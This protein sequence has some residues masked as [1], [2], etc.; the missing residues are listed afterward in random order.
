MSR[1]QDRA[2]FIAALCGALMLVASTAAAARSVGI[3]EGEVRRT[4]ATTTAEEPSLGG[5]VLYDRL[6]PFTLRDPAGRTICAGHLQTRAVLSTAAGVLDF[7]Y[8]FRDTSGRGAI[9]GI[10]VSHF[11]GPLRVAYRT[12]GPGTVAPYQVYR[13][14]APSTR[15]QFG[16]VTPGPHLFC[17]AHEE[18]R[19]LLIRTRATRFVDGG[20]IAEII[21]G[22]PP[23]YGSSVSV[24]IVD[25]GR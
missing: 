9:Y 4:P 17:A 24:E 12:D 11:V 13:E 7:Y 18:S 16:F 22:V 5:H 3:S 1:R 19:F 20:G 8:R 23:G 21:G 14:A 2:H 6:V 25:P 15:V 10:Y